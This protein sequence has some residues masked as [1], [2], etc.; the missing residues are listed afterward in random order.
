MI[1]RDLLLLEPLR[2][3]LTCG[4]LLLDFL[5]GDDALLHRVDQ[6]HASRLQPALLA[7]VFRRNVDARRPLT[8][9]QPDR[10]W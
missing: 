10:P 6:E 5:V 8:R 3:R 2:I 1:E 9:A 4:Q 7:D